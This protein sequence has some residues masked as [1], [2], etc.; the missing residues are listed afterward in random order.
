MA[1]KLVDI[2]GRPVLKLSTGKATW[3][4]P[5]QV[6]RCTTSRDRFE[7]FVG[8]ADEASPANGQ[9]L[10]VEV[11]RNGRRLAT[12]DVAT[13]RTHA[14]E[15]LAALPARYRELADPPQAPVQFT[16][17]LQQLQDALTRQVVGQAGRE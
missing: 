15:Q 1:Y 10:L 7:D 13:A 2:G 3:P 9:P 8:L 17:A 14:R 5:K 4:G 16:P 11:M 12:P 6:W